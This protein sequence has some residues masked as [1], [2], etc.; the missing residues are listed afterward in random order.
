MV[1]VTKWQY[2]FQESQSFGQYHYETEQLRAEYEEIMLNKY[3]ADGCK[4]EFNYVI[5]TMQAF[6]HTVLETWSTHFQV[7]GFAYRIRKAGQYKVWIHVEN[8]ADIASYVPH[9]E[10]WGIGLP[11][12]TFKDGILGFARRVKQT[13]DWEAPMPVGCK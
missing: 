11:K 8:Y 2:G 7:G 3:V 13:Y 5:G 1:W 6:R 9:Y 10:P 4:K 12:D